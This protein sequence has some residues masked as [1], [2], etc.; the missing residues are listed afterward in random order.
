[1]SKVV[2]FC[3]SLARRT[4]RAYHLACAR[5]DAVSRRFAVPEGVWVCG[6][7]EA[8]LLDATDLSSHTA[9]GL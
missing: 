4:S 9:H 1:M 8:V 7:C 5:D 6:G 2:R 3:R